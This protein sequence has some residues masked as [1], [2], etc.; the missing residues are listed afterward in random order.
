MPTDR[1]A[2]LLGVPAELIDRLDRAMEGHTAGGRAVLDGVARGVGEGIARTVRAVEPKEAGAAALRQALRETVLAHERQLLSHLSSIA[3]ASQFEKTIT[4]AR[5]VATAKSGFFLKREFAKEI[6]LKR[7]PEHLIHYLGYRDVRELLEKEDVV[8]S[9]S[10]LR[11]MESDRWMHE[12]FDAAYGGFTAADFEERPIELRVLGPEWLE[13]AKRFVEKKHHNV[14]H[15][16][17]FGVIFLNPISEDIPG[18]FLRDFAL[19]LHYCH[20]I[21]FYAKLF[22]RYRGEPN[23][24]DRLRS[25]LR[26]DVPEASRSTPGTWLIVQQYLWKEHPEDSRL[27]LPRVNPESLHW[28]RAERDL[29]RFASARADLG[30]ELW[31]GLDWVADFYPGGAGRELVSFDLEDNVMSAVSFMEGQRACYTYHQRE[32]LWS[33]LFME[34]VGGEDQMEQ[35]LAEH[36][37]R[38]TITM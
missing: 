36:F 28:I 19:L 13:V 35:A 15:L 18:K 26:G 16:K 24:A 27:S 37:A 29:A 22:R 7:P 31:E 14:S 1:I 10:A 8:E 38:G 11:F 2:E 3:G 33:K 12:T 4:L 9:F 30:L 5:Q 21:E 17:E 23:F 34:Y 25:L 6:L 32:A 20:E